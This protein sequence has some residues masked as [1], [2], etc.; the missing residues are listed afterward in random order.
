MG[1]LRA[2]GNFLIG[3]GFGEYNASGYLGEHPYSGKT[4]TASLTLQEAAK[5]REYAEEH[6]ICL[7]DAAE[8]LYGGR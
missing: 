4:F 2:I 7:T 5:V 3:E 8:R 1:I 6:R